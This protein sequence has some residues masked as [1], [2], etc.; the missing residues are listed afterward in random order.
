MKTWPLLP[1]LFALPPLAGCA[2]DDLPKLYF[3]DNLRIVALKSDPVTVRPGGSTTFSGLVADPKGSGRAITYT[4]EICAVTQL[5][6]TGTKCAQTISTSSQTTT[7]ATP[8]LSYT[9]PFTTEAAFA[10]TL[11]A[12][13]GS[14]TR[15]SLRT[16]A[17]VSAA[18]AETAAPSLSGFTINGEGGT[19]AVSLASGRSYRLAAATS[20]VTEGLFFI[21]WIT[22]GGALDA[23]RTGSREN[24][25]SPPG[26]AG[27]YNI[28]VVLNDGNGG[29]DFQTRQVIVP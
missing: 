11:Q 3:A 23:S 14:E 17:V 10:V 7:S 28:Y 4:W 15:T 24:T 6:G 19:A 22:D 21:T 20:G 2:G 29:V 16:V 27:T 5:D 18:T 26:A 8:S 9:N 13:A 12:T 25:Y 1:L